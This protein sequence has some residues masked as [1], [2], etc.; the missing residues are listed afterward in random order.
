MFLFVGSHYVSNFAFPVSFKDARDVIPINYTEQA[1]VPDL[2]GIGTHRTP[3]RG[4]YLVAM[5][6]N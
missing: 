2:L 6:Q 4:C 3:N 5:L 1:G